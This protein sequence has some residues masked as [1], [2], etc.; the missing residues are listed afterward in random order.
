MN[1]RRAV[2]ALVEAEAAQV[3]PKLNGGFSSKAY[4]TEN[5]I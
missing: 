5:A 4:R 1:P 2:L 3:R